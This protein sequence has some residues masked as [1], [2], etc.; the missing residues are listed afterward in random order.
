[1]QNKDES[2]DSFR[3]RLYTIDESGKRL[4]VFAKNPKGRL[5]TARNITGI[6]LMIFFFSAPFIKINGQ[7]LLLFDFFRRTFVIFGVQFWPQDFNL[8]FIGMIAMMVFIILFTVTYGRI[9]C[10]WA[11]PQTIFMEVVFRRIEYWIDGDTH[12]QKDLDAAPWNA[13]KIFRR[14]LKH[15]VFYLISFIISNYFL[16]YI[17]GSDAWTHMVTESPVNHL[18]GLAGMA[19]F[20]FIFYFIFSWFREQVCTIVCPYGRLQ[21]VLLDRETVVISYDYNRGE[22][23]APL[24]KG[25]NRSEIKKGDCIDCHQC[26]AVCPT[27]IDIRNGT[28]LE[29]INCA[30]CIDACNQVMLRTGLKPGL[31]RYASEKMIADKKPWHYTVRSGAYTIVLA[32]LLTAFGYFLISRNPVEATVLRSPGMLFQEQEGGEISNLYSVKVV[33]KTNHDLPLEIRDMSGL[34]KVKIIGNAPVIAK[35]SLGEVVF[36]LLMDREKLTSS[37]TEVEIGIFSGG[38]KL[39]Q[40][41]ATFVGPDK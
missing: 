11:C 15:G 24:R 41:R 30:C 17:M 19:I 27:G 12:R 4:W 7:Q 18:P 10:G 20:S 16:M 36:F 3:D 26:V 5:T 21:G 6:L 22:E 32:L 14:V 34:G 37:K 28:Q 35:Q 25:E 8:F 31:I 38:K 33:N 13:D 1:M 40:T 39:D 2:S 29:C 23:R 9:W